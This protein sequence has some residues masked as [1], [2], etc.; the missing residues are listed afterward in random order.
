MKPYYE[1]GGITIYHGNCR[2][3]LNVNTPATAVISDPPWGVGAN[4]DY[5]RF[6]GGLSDSRNHGTAIAGDD[7]PFSP[8]SLFL[9]GFQWMALWG[10]HCFSDRLPMGR[11]LVWMKKRESQLGTFMS[12]AE[13]CWVKKERWPN[14]APGCYAYKHVWH[15]FDRQGAGK[16]L[17]PTEKPVA[18]MEWTIEMAEVPQTSTILDPY[19]GSGSTLVAAKNRGHRAIGVEIAE[20]YCEIAAERLSQGVLSL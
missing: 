12:D 6:V 19:M 5:T 15:G 2:E 14:R 17:H 18:L 11:W 1:S 10:A 8:A 3:I 16:V 20:K 9:Y 7:E 4:T 13:L